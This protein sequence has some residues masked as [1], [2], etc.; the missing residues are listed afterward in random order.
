M[1][2]NQQS[3]CATGVYNV[4]YQTNDDAL[5]IPNDKNTHQ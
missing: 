4:D 2:L 5:E 1:F 3:S